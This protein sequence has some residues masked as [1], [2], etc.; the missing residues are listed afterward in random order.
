MKG[1]YVSNNSHIEDIE[2][3]RGKKHGD[4]LSIVW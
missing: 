3:E 2:G 4:V 1:K